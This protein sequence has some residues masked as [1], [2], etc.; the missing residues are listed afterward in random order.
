MWKQHQVFDGT[1][2][3]DD[4]LDAHELLAVTNENHKRDIKAQKMREGGV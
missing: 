3:L 1:Y 2:N 4:L